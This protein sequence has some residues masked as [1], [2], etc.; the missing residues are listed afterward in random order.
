MEDKGYK[1]VFSDGKVRVW[2]K[3]F[4]DAFTLGFR[5]DSL[6]QV[7]GS[8]LG[9]MSCDTSLQFELWHPKF[10]HLHYKALPD[11]RKMVTGMPEF[12][13]EQEGACPGCAEGKLKR[14]PFPSS[15][16]KTSDIFQ[17]VHSN[18]SGMMPVNS[19]GGY[20]YYLTF[21]DDYSRKTWIYFLK[22][23]D[24]VFS[25]FWHFKA[26]IENQTEKRIKTLRTD[27]GTE[28]ESNEFHEF[29]KEAGIKRETTT[30]YTLEQNGVAERKNRT[31]MEAIRAML[32]DQSLPKFLWAEAANTAVYVQ[33]RCPH[34]ALGSKTPKEKFTGKKPDVCHFKIFGSPVYFHVPKVRTKELCHKT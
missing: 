7:R 22:K 15:Q 12:R 27:N 17:L 6:Y 9:V 25:W 2:K 20:L 24:E 8:P 11:V 19:L 5:V 34:Q 29:C 1:V 16:S 26:L 31:I 30:P 13:L 14:G 23:K 18:I 4:K 28:Y 21:T 3:N 33:N 10:A 32:H